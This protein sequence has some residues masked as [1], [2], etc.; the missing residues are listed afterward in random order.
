MAGIAT[1][2]VSFFCIP[3]MTTK[4]ALGANFSFGLKI[5]CTFDEKTHQGGQNYKLES[6]KNCKISPHIRIAISRLEM[7]FL[8]FYVLMATLRGSYS[9]DRAS[10][11]R[12]LRRWPSGQAGKRMK[13]WMRP[14][15]FAI[16]EGDQRPSN[17]ETRYCKIMTSMGFVI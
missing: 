15:S 17:Q 14:L 3:S 10:D 16:R 2:G 11:C 6:Q 1:L 7:T 4:M 12:R 13:I 5:E 8:I 9:I